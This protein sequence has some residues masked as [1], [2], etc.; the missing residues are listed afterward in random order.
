MCSNA[1]IRRTQT[2]GLRS[3]FFGFAR[4]IETR[5]FISGNVRIHAALKDLLY[6]ICPN[7]KCT[8]RRSA[9]SWS[10]RGLFTIAKAAPPPRCSTT[11][12]AMRFRGSTARFQS[13]MDALPANVMFCD[14]DDSA[15]I[16][17]YLQTRSR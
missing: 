10:V 1:D 16:N 4:Q 7:C 15:L 11:V 13:A 12:K 17:N 8:C 6:V 5:G 3:G 2:G 14:R 9:R